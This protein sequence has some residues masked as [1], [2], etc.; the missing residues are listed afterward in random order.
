MG[1]SQTVQNKIT[2]YKPKG[3]LDHTARF[4]LALCELN[5]ESTKEHVERVAL[6]AEATAKSLKKDAKAAF[7]AGILHDI[8]KLVL[9]AKLFDGH[10]VDTAEYNEIK[11]HAQAGFKALQKFHLFVALCAGLHHNLYKAGYGLTVDMFPKEWSPATIKKVLDISTIIS[12]CDFVDAFTHRT[13]KIKDGSDQGQPEPDLKEILY[14]K[15]SNDL[16]VVDTVLKQ[17]EKRK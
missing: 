7:F 11:T 6:L 3:G 15:Y 14:T 2:K 16:I 12:I 10:N 1:T 4:F 8:G 13:T 9:S 17:I 5:H